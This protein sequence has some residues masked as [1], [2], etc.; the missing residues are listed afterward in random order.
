M[1]S[2]STKYKNRRLK[3]LTDTVSI[4]LQ[5]DMHSG[6]VTLTY[7]D[8]NETEVFVSVLDYLED[9]N[10]YYRNRLEHIESYEGKLAL[11]ETYL[12]FMYMYI[13]DLRSITL[14]KFKEKLEEDI[15]L[16]IEQF[17]YFKTQYLA[18]KP[19]LTKET[20]DN[21]LSTDEKIIILDYLGVF[22]TMNTHEIIDEARARIIS[23]LLDRSFDNTKK[24]IRNI[25][26]KPKE[27][28]AVKSKKKLETVL[29]LANEIKYQFLIDKVKAD[30]DK[31]EKK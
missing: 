5:F 31:I 16:Y 18:Y 17:T 22:E 20:A 24:G 23:K 14:N 6:K 3:N 7:A 28:D 27:H 8:T 10:M 4:G 21:S 26:G 29:Q 25:G 15:R 12:N 9:L 1:T 13:V 11:C 19:A 2:T 30:L